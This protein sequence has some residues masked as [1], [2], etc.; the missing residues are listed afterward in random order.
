MFPP[1]QALIGFQKI[2]DAILDR[3]KGEE[4][5]RYCS[6]DGGNE[7]SSWLWAGKNAREAE[8]RVKMGKA[9][10]YAVQVFYSF[11]IM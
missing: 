7:R 1:S 11:F 9:A 6:V 5:S 3:A 8:T 10:L 2:R 4:L